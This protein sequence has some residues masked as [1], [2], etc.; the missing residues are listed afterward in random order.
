MTRTETPWGTW[1][2]FTP[3]EAAALLAA[4]DRPWWFAGGYAIEFAVGRAYREHEDIDIM[5]LR[6]D[7]ALIQEVLPSWEWWA[8]DPPGTLRPWRPGEVLPAGVHDIWCRPGPEEP[9]RIQFMLDE[10]EGEEWVSRREPVVRRPLGEY[11]RLTVDGLP[12]VAPEIQLFYKSKGLRPKD[13]Q[14]FEQVLPILTQGERDW[15]MAVLALS[16]QDH[17]WIRR[18]DESDQN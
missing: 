4:T 17:P 15:L 12:Y 1:E 10:S 11:G 16:S 18:I 7:Q 3:A 6:Q 14:D 2:P 8:A 9:W 13:E 5:V